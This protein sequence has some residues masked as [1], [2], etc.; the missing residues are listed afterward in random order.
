MKKQITIGIGD[1]A[2]TAK[3]FTPVKI[4]DD[5]AVA[6]LCETDGDALD[7]VVEAPPLLENDDARGGFTGSRDGA[8][9]IALFSIRSFVSDFF[10][11]GF[12][13]FKLMP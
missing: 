9:G 6:D 3:D 2:T 1:A 12:L 8:V 10:L 11:H 13:L 7:L 5:G 4:R